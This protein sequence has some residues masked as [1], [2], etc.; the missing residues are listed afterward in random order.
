MRS[1]ALIL[2]LT[3]LA[4]PSLPTQDSDAAGAELYRERAG[5]IV[6]GALA[7]GR[8]WPMLEELC[9][10]APLRLAGSPGAERAVQWALEAMRAAGLE[11]VHL[12]PCKVP[13]WERGSCAELSVLPT[14]E[15]GAAEPLRILALGGSVATPAAGLT[16]G[17]VEVKSFEELAAL[18]EGARGRIVFFNRPMDPAL[19]DTFAAYGGAVDQRTR[20]AAAAARAGGVA[21]IVRSMTTR[22]DDSPHTGAMRYEAGMERVP[23]AA[24]STLGAERLSGLLRERPDLRVRLALDCRT[25]DEVD[26]A[27]VVGEL[28]GAERPEEVVLLGAHLDAWDVGQGASDDGAGCVQVIEAARLVAT[29][30]PKPRRTIRVVLFANEENGLRGAFAYAEAHADELEH[31]VLALESDRGGFV[32]RGFVSDANPAAMRS[33]REV[34]GLLADAGAGEVRECGPGQGG[35]DVWPLSRAGVITAGLAPDPQRYFDVHH[36]ERDVLEQVNPR[37][38]ALGAGVIGAFAYGVA[39]LPDRLPSNDAGAAATGR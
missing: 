11:N 2:S 35:A 29:T 14:L 17:V 19:V 20:G 4:L 23:A 37:E 1:T 26:S 9:T 27:N 15:D 25:L 38:L 3:L 31:H 16:A 32:P 28:R 18:G 22:L 6:R 24:V 8:A 7:E 21:A 39:D 13:R 34:A 33:L 30:G 5:R 10:A 36:S 12:E